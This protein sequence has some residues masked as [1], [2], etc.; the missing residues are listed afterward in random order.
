MLFQKK[1][2]IPKIWDN[3]PLK[4]THGLLQTLFS[5]KDE[6]TF[7]KYQFDRRTN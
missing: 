3:K 5:V 2:K 6:S 7:W 4:L 1:K